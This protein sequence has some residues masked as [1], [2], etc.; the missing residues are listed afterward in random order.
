M[1]TNLIATR[2]ANR[3]SGES[4]GGRQIIQPYCFMILLR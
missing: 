1:S 2:G 4:S 3:K